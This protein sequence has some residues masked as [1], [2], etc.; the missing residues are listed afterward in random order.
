M[1]N[2]ALKGQR[3]TLTLG[4]S[5]AV[6]QQACPAVD[7]Y[8]ECHDNSTY[9][10]RAAVAPVQ[11]SE[12]ESEGD[13]AFSKRM[14]NWRRTVRYLGSRGGGCCASWAALYVA[15]RVQDKN[16]E[17]EV[18]RMPRAIV[19]VDQLDGWLVEAAVR[20]MI[21]F[22]EKQALRYRYVWQYSEHWIKTKLKLRRTGVRLV[23]ARAQRDLQQ[24]L[25]KLENPV[26]ILSNNLHAGVDPRPESTDAHVGASLTLK[27]DEALID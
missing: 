6:G 7:D 23:L 5:R 20:S 25:A 2:E 14:D 19:T 21:S 22:D 4:R 17:A 8:V 15:C 12:A 9:Q 27:K 24:I 18:A 13:L 16:A 1:K 11:I 26:R 10:P 3:D